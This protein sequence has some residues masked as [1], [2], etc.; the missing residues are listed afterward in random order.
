MMNVSSFNYIYSVVV[1]VMFFHV[2]LHVN[3]SY[4][5]ENLSPLIKTDNTSYTAESPIPVMVKETVS[6]ISVHFTLLLTRN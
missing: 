1:V 5:L 6:Y 4:N 2:F 3:Y